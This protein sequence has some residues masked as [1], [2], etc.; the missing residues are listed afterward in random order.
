MR[1]VDLSVVLDSDTPSDP[2]YQ[3]P[4]IHYLNHKQTRDQMLSF[5]PDA[6]VKD[7]PEGN[8]WSIEF[9]DVCTHAG[10]HLDA[11]YHYYPTQNGGERA[12]TIDEIP[13]DWCFGNGVKMDFSDKP[14]CYKITKDDVTAYFEKHRYEVK[15]GD[16]V[17]LQSGASGRWGTAEYLMAGAGMSYDAT[18]WLL[19]KGVNVVGT[20]AWSWDVPLAS[21]GD[22]FSETRDASILWEAHR[23]GR[24]KAYCHME[25]MSNL[26]QLPLTGFKVCCFPIK[27]DAAGAGWTRAVAIFDD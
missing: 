16:I 12:W 22:T 11:P 18:M 9:L 2:E 13:L 17:L 23:V 24:E 10:T 1:F 14:D 26:E 15:K 3:R 27:I 8:A 20:D 5:F 19:D 7:L 25:K 21:I 6:T 4:H